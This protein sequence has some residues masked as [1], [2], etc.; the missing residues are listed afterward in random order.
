VLLIEDSNVQAGFLTKLLV[1]LGLTVAR[2]ATGEEALKIVSQHKFDLV[3]VDYMLEESMTG[4]GVIRGIR[5]MSGRIGN[6]PILAISGFDDVPRR[7]EMLRSGAN[8]FVHKPVVPEEFQVRVRNLIQLR[9]ALDHLEEQHRI[10]HDM[11]MQDRLTAVYNRH[12]LNERMPVLI[13]ASIAG[14]NPLSLIVVD[15]DHFKRINDN[16]GHVTGDAVLA[17][18]AATLRDRAGDGSMVARLGGEEFIVVLPGS[19]IYLAGSKAE[20]LR[21][22]IEDLE[23]SGLPVTASFGV[24]QLRMGDLYETVFSRADS[25]MYE[26][27]QDGRNRVVSAE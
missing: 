1:A 17:S 15:V 21:E 23:P 13:S 9:Q 8:D 22:A 19:D 11:A 16:F 4:L 5:A 2:V 10:L 14:N 7:I 25:A 12:Y 24:A 20:Q 6:L 3:L 26:A 27:K 18:I